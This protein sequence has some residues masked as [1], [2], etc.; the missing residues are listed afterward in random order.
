MN[1]IEELEK[2]DIQNFVDEDYTI[3]FDMNIIYKGKP[4]IVHIIFNDYDS[5]NPRTVQFISDNLYFLKYDIDYL[6]PNIDTSL[7]KF[8]QKL[9]EIDISKKS[10]DIKLFSIQFSGGLSSYIFGDSF[11]WFDCSFED[12]HVIEIEF[13]HWKVVDINIV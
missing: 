9:Y 2:F 10:V 6:A 3:E 13:K 8:I 11:F 1:I 7:H 4:T 5:N 12:E